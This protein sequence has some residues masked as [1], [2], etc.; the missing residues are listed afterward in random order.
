MD[1]ERKFI[2][3]IVGIV[4][5]GICLLSGSLYGI[6]S[7]KDLKMAK[8]GFQQTMVTGS[9]TPLYQKVP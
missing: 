7:Y 1:E 5:L 6:Y 2:C 4:G 3:W 8:M 9:Q